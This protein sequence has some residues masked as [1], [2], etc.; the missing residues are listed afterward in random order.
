[1]SDDEHASASRA[2]SGIAEAAATAA[3][4][5]TGLSTH[6]SDTR[7]SVLPANPTYG[8]HSALVMK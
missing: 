7:S 1:M 4:H 5:L 2:T 6:R 8:A 3:R